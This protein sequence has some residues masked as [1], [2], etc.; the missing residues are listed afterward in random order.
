V[1]VR[2]MLARLF[3]TWIN[4]NCLSWCDPL[5]DSGQQ[6]LCQLHRTSVNAPAY[7]SI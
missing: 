3:N 6:N 5:S 2:K 1:S 4:R 7:L